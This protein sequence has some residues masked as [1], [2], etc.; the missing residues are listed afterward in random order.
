MSIQ[1]ETNGPVSRKVKLLGTVLLVIGVV[2]NPWTI[3]RIRANGDLSL[4]SATFILVANFLIAAVGG[5][6]LFVNSKR[7]FFRTVLIGTSVG[8][9]LL[10][11]VSATELY[12]ATRPVTSDSY[13]QTHIQH[14]NPFYF[15]SLPRTESEL[16][17]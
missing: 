13:H 2:L 16:T 3:V 15:F 4:G 9:W 12:L 5:L 6:L 7:A 1:S 11:S 8:A 17:K 10:A 14:L